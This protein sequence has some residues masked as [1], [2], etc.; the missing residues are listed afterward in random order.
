MNQTP[1]IVLVCSDGDSTR[2]IA[3]A[4]EKKFGPITLVMENS[5]SKWLMTKRRVKRLGLLTTAGQ[6][7]FILAVTPVLRRA[8]RGRIAEIEKRH[9]LGKSF[10]SPIISVD[11]INSDQAIEAIRNLSPDVIVVSGTRIIGKKLLNAVSAPVINMHAGI[12]PLYRGVHGGYWALFENKPG[13]VGTTVHLVDAG[14]DTGNV[15]EQSYFKV[16]GTDNFAT[17]PYLHTAAGIPALVRA[18]KNALDGKL[19]PKPEENDL[20]SQLR[21]HPTIWQYLYGRF[22]KGVR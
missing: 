14:I 15:I 2:A 10:D 22:F 16:N 21:Y 8:G 7:A 1:K 3:G 19:E 9:G 17:Y 4:L 6:L 11:S 12:T 20:D 13:L 5:I 18:V